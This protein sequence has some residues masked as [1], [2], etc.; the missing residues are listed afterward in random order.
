M[1]SLAGKESAVARLA[2]YPDSFLQSAFTETGTADEPSRQTAPRPALRWVSHPRARCARS[3]SVRLA[4]RK[5]GSFA[6]CRDGACL[7]TNK[8]RGEAT[9]SGRRLGRP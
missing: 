7:N 8:L 1:T 2:R 3:H 9:F 6:R 4:E 5:D